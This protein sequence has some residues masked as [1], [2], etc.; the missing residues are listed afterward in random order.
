MMTVTYTTP[1]VG[2]PYYTSQG[3]IKVVDRYDRR[4]NV[5]EISFERFDEQ[6]F[7]YV[8]KPYWNE[9]KYIPKGVFNGIPGIN[10]DI[11][12]E[13]YYRVNMTPVFISMRTPSESRE[14]IRELL[15]SVKL[16]YYDRF[17]WLLR[18]NSRCGDDNI[19]VIRK[20][21]GRDRSIENIQDENLSVDDIVKID[22][23]GGICSTNGRMVEKT[24]ILLQSGAKIFIADENRFLQEEE[25][26]NM[27]YLLMNMLASQD[28]N[29]K[30]NRI[31]GIITAKKNGKYGGRK[32]IAVDAILLQ[33]ISYQFKNKTISEKDAMKKLGLVSRS[34]FY[35]KIKQ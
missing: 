12:R 27:L 6:N 18:S 31:N 5:G 34:T 15:S 9:I 32:P 26:N 24:F 30:V 21:E 35:R 11:K 19:I 7:Q 14:D 29:N 20:Y 10:M 33:Q 22:N 17:E 2:T 25:R 28:R 8:I 13:K 1:L 16:D 23:L 3:L 4:Y